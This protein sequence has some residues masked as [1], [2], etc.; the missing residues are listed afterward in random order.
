[1]AVAKQLSP[2]VKK[3]HVITC[4]GDDDF[5]PQ[6]IYNNIEIHSIIKRKC[7]TITKKRYIDSYYKSRLFETYSMNDRPLNES[8]RSQL[9]STLENFS[10]LPQIGIDYGHGF[11]TG[12]EK[13]FAV[14]AQLNAG[15]KGFN[16]IHKYKNVKYM[17][18]DEQEMRLEMKDKKSHIKDLNT[19]FIANKKIEAV[20]TTVGSNGCV[21]NTKKSHNEIPALRGLV[22]DT[23]GAGDAFFGMASCLLYLGASLD[24]SCFLGNVTGYLVANTVGLGNTFYNSLYY[25]QTV[26]TFLK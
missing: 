25:K 8:E 18:L 16:Y 26:N 1:M 20:I 2:L 17:V 19:R 12:N 23:V 22:Q 11:L 14:N 21:W 10:T 7:P 6:E 24:L 13:L 15:N 9:N 5:K 4:F 3:V